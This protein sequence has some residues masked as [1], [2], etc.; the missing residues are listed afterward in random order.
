MDLLTV[1]MHELGH[2]LG[3]R[4]HKCRRMRRSM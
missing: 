1:V 2:E 3:L 4:Y